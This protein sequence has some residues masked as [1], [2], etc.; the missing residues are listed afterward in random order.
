MFR[1]LY[2]CQP[3]GCWIRF[4]PP[5][6][7]LTIDLRFYIRKSFLIIAIHEIFQC[8]IIGIG[9]FFLPVILLI[10]SCFPL[11]NAD[12]NFRTRKPSVSNIVR[13]YRCIDKNL[14][15]AI[16]HVKDLIRYTHADPVSIF[17]HIFFV[18]CRIMPQI[19]IVQPFF[20]L[21]DSGKIL[22]I[23]IYNVIPVLV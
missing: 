17:V 6:F 7:C 4:L 8:R 9:I 16:D 22:P 5:G 20:P 21:P 2:F 3:I 10:F 11:S 15:L 18:R 13:R 12:K 19:A 1:F 23:F 14:R